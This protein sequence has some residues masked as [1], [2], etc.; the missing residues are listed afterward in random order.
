MYTALK[1]PRPVIWAHRP[2]RSCTI[3][4]SAIVLTAAPVGAEQLR[5]DHE[6]VTVEPIEERGASPEHPAEVPQG[7]FEPVYEDNSPQAAVEP[8]VHE[9]TPEGPEI[10]FQPVAEPALEPFFPAQAGQT[11]AEAAPSEADAPA[12]VDPLMEAAEA[13]DK[14]HDASG[15]RDTENAGGE[16][17][18]PAAA[19]PAQAAA[20]DRASVQTAAPYAPKAAS[21][22]KPGKGEKPVEVAAVAPDSKTDIFDQWAH[23]K[24]EARQEK[25]PHPLAAQHPDEF[26]VVCEAGCAGNPVEI[27]YMERRDARGPVN[28][29]PLKSGLVASTASIDCV[30]GCYEG[31]NAY[32]AVAVTWDPSAVVTETAG[33][34]NGWMTTV[35]K[36]GPQPADKTKADSSGR[37]YDRIN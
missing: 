16:G 15:G 28:E 26:V 36:A 30:G 37:W 1:F 25:A 4:L 14:A 12:G 17:S 32:G 11:A 3:L 19:A 13:F 5:M 31:R 29:K 6:N 9:T 34:N 23:S 18:A 8:A 2:I 27:V 7:A 24:F 22:G 21:P 10:D 33:T 20:P 35:K